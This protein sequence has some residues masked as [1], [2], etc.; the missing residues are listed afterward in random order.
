MLNENDDEQ[1]QG[2]S[3]VNEFRGMLE[4]VSQNGNDDE[5]QQ[6]DNGLANLTSLEGMNDEDRKQVD[7][8]ARSLYDAVKTRNGDYSGEELMRRTEDRTKTADVIREKMK[9]VIDHN[10]DDEQYSDETREAQNALDYLNVHGLDNMTD[11]DVGEIMAHADGLYDA[12]EKRRGHFRV[13][14]DA[15]KRGNNSLA[16]MAR[17]GVRMLTP[18]ELTKEDQEEVRNLKTAGELY[19]ISAPKRINGIED[20]HGSGDFIDYLSEGLGENAERMAGTVAGAMIGA[21]A[22]PVVGAG[23]VIGGMAG[24][25][26][27]GMAMN[28]GEAVGD[29]LDENLDV[30]R[31]WALAQ[32]AGY[33]VL[34]GA[35]GVVPGL[36]KLFSQALKT[37]GKEAAKKTGATAL[38]EY[39]KMA[40]GRH[41][42]WE[43]L[44]M[45]GGEG[46][47]EAAQSQ[48]VGRGRRLGQ[49]GSALKKDESVGEAIMEGVNEFV[50]GASLALVTGGAG[51]VMSH[52]G[53]K[54]SVGIVNRMVNKIRKDEAFNALTPEYQLLVG[55][56]L[57][58]ECLLRTNSHVGFLTD[59]Y[60]ANLAAQ[61]SAIE[62]ELGFN[63]RAGGSDRLVE[64]EGADDES[65][66]ARAVLSGMHNA[67]ALEDR[68]TIVD[69][70][71]R[72]GFE[73]RVDWQAMKD[74]ERE[75][76]SPDKGWKASAFY[77]RVTRQYLYKFQRGKEERYSIVQPNELKSS[78]TGEDTFD[79]LGDALNA[80]AE[81]DVYNQYRAKDT[82]AKRAVMK[83]IASRL[84]GDSGVNFVLVDNKA[85][86]RDE[87][88]RRRAAGENASAMFSPESNTVY[89]F[90]DEVKSLGDLY[91]SLAHETMHGKIANYIKG[92]D[93]ESRPDAQ[94]RLFAESGIRGTDEFGRAYGTSDEEAGEE[95]LVERLSVQDVMKAVN[96][97]DRTLLGAGVR[98]VL[99]AVGIQ[100]ADDL[101]VAHESITEDDVRQELNFLWNTGKAGDVEVDAQ[102]ARDVAL[103][104]ESENVDALADEAS[105]ARERMKAANARANKRRQ[106]MRELRKTTDYQSVLGEDDG[107]EELP[108]GKVSEWDQ[109]VKDKPKSYAK[110]LADMKLKDGEKSRKRFFMEVAENGV[111]ALVEGDEAEE[112]D[113]NGLSDETRAELAGIE[114]PL[115][116]DEKGPVSV[117]S[118]KGITSRLEA[119][120]HAEK[121]SRY[122]NEKQ[123]AFF[124]KWNAEKPEGTTLVSAKVEKDGM[125]V[126]RSAGHGGKVTDTFVNKDG[127]SYSKYA[128]V[129][130]KQGKVL[131]G[132]AAQH[133]IE[134]DAE[135]KARRTF[136]DDNA[137]MTE[138][139]H[140]AGRGGRLLNVPPARMVRNAN[141]KGFHKE[142]YGDPA[143]ET[144]NHFLDGFKGKRREEMEDVLFGRTKRI[145]AATHGNDALLDNF[146]SD[147]GGDSKTDPR[148]N[149]Y[150]G[151]ISRFMEQYGE[152]EAFKANGQKTKEQIA[153]ED[154]EADAKAREVKIG[155]DS[156]DI[157]NLASDGDSRELYD[158]ALAEVEQ[159]GDAVKMFGRGELKKLNGGDIIRF[160]HADSDWIVESYND[161]AGEIVVTANDVAD[162]PLFTDEEK[163]ELTGR[164][165][166]I[167]ERGWVELKAKEVK[168]GT[169]SKTGKGTDETVAGDAQGGRKAGGEDLKLE[170]ATQEELNDEKKRNAQRKAIAEKQAAPLNGGTGEVGQSLLDLGGA[171]GEDLFNRTQ[172]SEQKLVVSKKETTTR[173]TEKKSA[174]P[175]VDDA[176]AAAKVLGMDAFI[177]EDQLKRK[178]AGWTR[179]ADKSPLWKSK[180][181]AAKV[182][183]ADRA[184][185]GKAD[186]KSTEVTPS[187]KAAARAEKASSETPTKTP[188]TAK[189]S[190]DVAEKPKGAR[191]EKSENTT[192]TDDGFA[193]WAV[194]RDGTPMKFATE[195]DRKT[196]R[197]L[198]DYMVRQGLVDGETGQSNVRFKR[199]EERHAEQMANNPEYREVYDRTFGKKGWLKAPNGKD[200]NLDPVQWVIVR[201]PSFRKWFGDWLRKYYTRTWQDI[202]ETSE[203][204]AIVP[205]DISAYSPLVDKNAISDA[206]KS[207]GEV[208]N[209][210]DGRS[211][212]FPSKSAGRFVFV[213]RYAGAFRELF[214]SSRRAW[215]ESETQFEGH[216]G[217]RNIKAYHHYINKFKTSDGEY[218]VRFTVR[219]GNPGVVEGENNVHSAEVSSVEL[220]KKGATQTVNLDRNVAPS[221]DDNAKAPYLDYKIANFLDRVNEESVSKVVDENGEPLVVWHGGKNNSFTSFEHGHSLE[222]GVGAVNKYTDDED[223]GFYFSPNKDYA[224]QYAGGE[225]PRAFWVS[226]KKPYS[227]GSG[228]DWDGRIDNWKSRKFLTEVMVRNA[229]QI[230]SA[231]DNTGAY[232]ADSNDIRFKRNAGGSL[233]YAGEF[234]LRFR[235]EI[236]S[237]G[238]YAGE[239]RNLAHGMKRGD[240][241]SMVIGAD[242]MSP[243]IPENAVIVPMPNHEGKPIRTMLLGMCISGVRDDVDVVPALL[244][245]P[246][247][248]SYHDKKIG[249]RPNL[250]MRRDWTAN[251]PK[252]RPVVVID[253]VIA[254]GATWEVAKSVLPDAT[255]VTLA[256][257]SRKAR[258]EEMSD[259]KSLSDFL[260]HPEP[261]MS[262]DAFKEK[263]GS[264]NLDGIYNKTTISSENGR[265]D[266]SQNVGDEMA[267]DRE[268]DADNDGS[269]GSSKLDGLRLRRTDDMPTAEA[270]DPNV[271][272]GNKDGILAKTGIER[273]FERIADRS[274]MDEGEKIAR[275][276]VAVNEIVAK[277]ERGDAPSSTD[278][279]ALIH[280]FAGAYRDAY[281][282]RNGMTSA[283]A[284]DRADEESLLDGKV[285]RIA[286]AL[287]LA[288]SR[289][290][291]ALQ[292][293]KIGVSLSGIGDTYAYLASEMKAIKA[294]KG[295]EPTLTDAERK[296]LEGQV[297]KL[298]AVNDKLNALLGEKDERIAELNDANR[299]LEDYRRNVERDISADVKK[300]FG[301]KNAKAARAGISVLDGIFSRVATAPKFARTENG[302]GSEPL[303]LND[304]MRNG[305]AAIVSGSDGNIADA[306]KLTKEM[307]GDEA[308]ALFD[309][310]AKELGAS[311]E[312]ETVI[313]GGTERAMRTEDERIAR[314]KAR[315][316]RKR[317]SLV[318]QLNNLEDEN[319]RHK[320][321]GKYVRDFMKYLVEA[322]PS[323]SNEDVFGRAAE[324]AKAVDPRGSYDP[325]TVL[326]IASNRRGYDP[327]TREAVNRRIGDLMRALELAR[328]GKMED[329]A[330]VAGIS[331]SGESDKLERMERDL[332]RM[333][334]EKEDRMMDLLENPPLDKEEQVAEINRLK[335]ELAETAELIRTMRREIAASEKKQKVIEALRK[336][337]EER[338]RELAE[339][340]APSEEKKARLDGEIA[341]LRRTIKSVGREANLRQS[342]ADEISDLDRRIREN[343]F[344]MPARPKAQ[345]SEKSS[346]VQRLLAERDR[347]RRQFK[348][349][350]KMYQYKRMAW[351]F[352]VAKDLV[353]IL[354]E[355]KAL[356]GSLDFSSVLRQGGQL[357]FA[358]PLLF[359]KNIKMTIEAFSDGEAASRMMAEIENRQNAKYYKEAGIDFTDYGEGATSADDRFALY[360]SASGEGRKLLDFYHKV[361][362]SRLVSKGVNASERAFAMYLNLMRA[363]AFDALVASTPA[364][365]ADRLTKSQLQAIGNF[366][367][368]A[369]QRGTV[370]KGSNLGKAINWMNYVLWSPRNL[371]SRFQFLYNTAK[372]VAPGTDPYGDRTLRGLFAKELA[373]YIVGV[374]TTIAV[375][376]FLSDL[377]RGEDEPPE[378]VEFDPRSSQFLRVRFGNTRVEFL[379]GLAQVLTFTSRWVTGKNKNSRGQLR[380][381]NFAETLGKFLRTKL[382]PAASFFWDYTSGETFERQ[383]IVW[384]KPWTSDKD[385]KSGYRHFAETF[386]PLTFSDVA[387]QAKLSGLSNTAVTFLMTILGAG[388]NAYDA[389]TYKQMTGDFHY[390]K[391]LFAE[392]PEDERKRIELYHPMVRMAG[393]IEANIKRVNSLQRVLKK[394]EANGGDA[395][396]VRDAI[397]RQ[398]KIVINLISGAKNPGQV[399]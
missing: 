372:L 89:V 49:T 367:N 311:K 188:A 288:G 235:R 105:A 55:K 23:A 47:Q 333:L 379:S 153:A 252:G 174:V 62:E 93:G 157:E 364:G 232:S 207:F 385:E 305:F 358:H 229:N 243:L 123:T 271:V 92:L 223:V 24:A 365:S 286:E 239:L 126:I 394:I 279:A 362:K 316:D 77:D 145:S 169:E 76:D 255:L 205:V 129:V 187:K 50:G 261:P 209:T 378:E 139:Q 342:I 308:A 73:N 228:D 194:A 61:N 111:N 211:V 166:R 297:A 346:E 214:E 124:E 246:H 208:V 182:I 83:D 265:L 70:A 135:A 363:D 167:T 178:I 299:T 37:V 200:T 357:T 1:T 151:F 104:D 335:K 19:D 102:S 33:S 165:F 236:A 257:A 192:P 328:Q 267:A 254:S 256:D 176:K 57:E 248:G 266:G 159:N 285:E 371:I 120:K 368:I 296:V 180:V 293:L 242:L 54:R 387:E 82:E 103:A 119:E 270:D 203:I 127:V 94:R 289:S 222:N 4:Y 383:D 160:D 7:D 389:L 130:N 44:K 227:K 181:E 22:A 287:R 355:S 143:A 330:S 210:N 66:A 78:I 75:I 219:E 137:H 241:R 15:L 275:D 391:R 292:M 20:I 10:G 80:L 397:E 74:S 72:N 217:H 338:Q 327:Q 249:K 28:T 234:Q 161:A 25:S 250:V 283:N 356:V 14:W 302:G 155:G 17:N 317:E 386:V 321:V 43:F 294:K 319:L 343:D 225:E 133:Q 307:Y 58:N 273:T 168:N 263:F 215:S 381:T 204:E 12:A 59:E 337:L 60:R 84:Y 221:M 97:G 68:Q 163:K 95:A 112:F 88:D 147:T 220:Y 42:V 323:L 152:Y 21:A 183:L 191:V 121:P 156:Y 399:D 34:D 32:G 310:Y 41:A 213:K 172:K 170:S 99:R 79:D 320:A 388:V 115:Q 353:T 277:V 107:D 278:L 376:K 53:A 2:S 114:P 110:F 26:A 360:D 8:Y 146:I 85:G 6:A 398:K 18:G 67:Y 132:A 86:I 272:F 366:L 134:S 197:S 46:A 56:H 230:K 29:Q 350:R 52:A 382:S 184:A 173:T 341:D 245:N 3:A 16:I 390:Y 304:A 301:I 375:A 125:L 339:T 154:A 233:D 396:A 274:V 131:S 195:E 253:N 318:N 35:F 189:E 276:T 45:L 116:S 347:M 240:M 186:A 324:E 374:A 149:D 344:E 340:S 122:G 193:A 369:S 349:A 206:F 9:F 108:T 164:R 64:S 140:Y 71:R 345:T 148:T 392:A 196:S 224:T 98:N 179:G 212:R 334:S 315:L 303:Y 373:K 31:G 100:M 190:L 30:S 117:P 48:I 177:P 306:R 325:E 138:F 39:G 158:T 290:G 268:D 13:F 298:K 264:R 309:Q 226:I 313:R 359:W 198:F 237:V 199:I 280:S 377:L 260:R 118:E 231:T 332:K 361:V 11:K 27:A 150:D 136:A 65:A 336:Q 216:K 141:G 300:R 284:S 251:I 218:Y 162:N 259:I 38:K 393:P 384:D 96:D 185:K 201:T 90:A 281:G 238:K 51:T 202:V 81:N 171:E 322:D 258:R 91:V 175:T 291:H 312:R 380:D 314:K 142:F 106:E 87:N 370:E 331:Y 282:L 295:L 101:G 351:P 244:V 63:R 36:N 5:R 348:H 269:S 144:I 329:A 109:L 40:A 352:Q 128:K 395:T 326:A 113:P 247:D 354:G 69:E 262:M